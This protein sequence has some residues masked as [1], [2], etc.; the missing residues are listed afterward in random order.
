MTQQ[1]ILHRSLK[2]TQSGVARRRFSRELQQ[3]LTKHRLLKFKITIPPKHCHIIKISQWFAIVNLLAVAKCFI[4]KI[5]SEWWR[6]DVRKQQ[7]SVLLFTWKLNFLPWVIASYVTLASRSATF[8]NHPK[9]KS[10]RRLVYNLIICRS[11]ALLSAS[12]NSATL[13]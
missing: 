5:S 1:R 11:T 13:P 7:K 10:A 6:S 3:E 12:R 4:F 8:P 9:I 2:E